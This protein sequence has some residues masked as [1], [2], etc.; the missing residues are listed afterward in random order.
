MVKKKVLS[1]K[2]IINSHNS[3]LVFPQLAK[4]VTF[5]ANSI[6][7]FFKNEQNDLLLSFM[8][9]H[10][11]TYA[12]LHLLMY[13]A[14]IILSIRGCLLTSVINNKILMVVLG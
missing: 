11:V 4:L 1:I 12:V 14:Q 9:S 5:A 8:S 7:I 3:A 6:N 2:V 10:K 13:L